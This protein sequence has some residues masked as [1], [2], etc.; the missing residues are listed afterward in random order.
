MNEVKQLINKYARHPYRYTFKNNVIIADT[1]D[2]PL[3]FKRKRKDNTNYLKD[4]FKYLKSRNFDYLPEIITS[5][6]EYDIYKYIEEINAPRD[7]KA[8]DL[9]YLLTLLH[10]KTSFYREIDH[11]QYKE[12]YEQIIK[13]L[14]Y[15]YH[16]YTNL[17]TIIEQKVYMSP[18]EYLLARNISKIYM[19]ISF[20]QKEIEE[21]YQL[22]KGKTKKRLATIHNNLDLDHLIHSDNPYLISWD[23]AIVDAPIYDIYHFYK[24]NALEF[25]FSELFRLYESKYPLLEEERK[26]LFILLSIPDLIELKYNEYE[27][28]CE[29]RHKIDYLY[30]TESLITPYYTPKKVKET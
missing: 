5:E 21:W 30:K 29:V 20:G 17:I 10:N 13:W 25:D 7:Q 18:S 14:D 1:D 3:V 9:I 24:K 22:V 6:G 4:L 27:N 16:Y 11:D 12:I 8:L 19:A 23:R 28:C 15:L 2:G 26:L